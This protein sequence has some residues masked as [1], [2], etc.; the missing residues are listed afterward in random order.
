[1]RR[2]ACILV[3]ALV[4][5]GCA[6]IGPGVIRGGRSAYN[7]TIVATNNQ[8]LLAMI[9]RTRYRE[10]SGLLAVSSIFCTISIPFAAVFLDPPCSWMIKNSAGFPVCAISDAMSCALRVSH[11]SPITSAPAT[12]GFF[13]RPAS[14]L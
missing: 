10:S 7:D 3:L 8:Q 4:T 6:L 13:P 5:Q 1:M 14:A 2:L 12:F 11:P 9:V